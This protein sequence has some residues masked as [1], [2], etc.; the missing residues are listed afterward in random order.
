MNLLIKTQNISFVL[1]KFHADSMLITGRMYRCNNVYYGAHYGT[2]VE[3]TTLDCIIQKL[4]FR[5]GIDI[6]F[7]PACDSIFFLNILI[8]AE[9][10]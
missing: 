1:I 6:R 5:S 2:T 4:P 10:T 7:P 8:E 3:A 9:S